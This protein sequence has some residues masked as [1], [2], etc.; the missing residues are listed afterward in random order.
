MAQVEKT[1]ELAVPHYP[2]DGCH[3]S[4]SCL[5]CP[6]PSCWYEMSEGEREAYR[7][8]AGR[9][10]GE[11]QA[12]G[13]NG[14][15][16]GPSR[17]AGLVIDEKKVALLVRSNQSGTAPG[18]GR[19]PGKLA[20]NPGY[21]QIMPQPAA[22]AVAGLPASPSAPRSPKT[23]RAYSTYWA[24]WQSWASAQEVEP[25]PADPRQVVAFVTGLSEGGASTHAVKMAF[26]AIR[27]YHQDAGLPDP[28]LAEDVKRARAELRRTGNQ[29]ARTPTGLTRLLLARIQATASRPR[30]YR[31]GR[32]EAPEHALARGRTDVALVS[33]MRDAMLRPAEAS[34]IT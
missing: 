34:D 26:S 17:R 28:T 2:D 25:L 30:T 12:T 27:A 32:R 1:R 24:K 11:Q 7:R 6:L 18:P 21:Q 33:L 4:S 31:D 8:L 20:I 16:P 22:T 19:S 14:R 9:G 23:L 15:K 10:N 3:V 5:D 13:G 29:P